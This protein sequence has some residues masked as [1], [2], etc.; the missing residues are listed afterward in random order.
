MKNLI[1]SMKIKSLL[2][3]FFLLFGFFLQAE[4]VIPAR[5]SWSV[6]PSSL[7]VGEVAEVI[8]KVK[9]DKGWYLYSS[10]FDPE[11][12]PVVTTVNFIPNSSFETIG[13]LKPINPHSK[14]DKEIWGGTYTYFTDLGEFRQKIKIK[15]ANWKIEGNYDSQACSNESGLCVPIKGGFKLSGQLSKSEQSEPVSN[16]S[17]PVSKV[18]G[19]SEL[20]SKVSE[21]PRVSTLGSTRS[22]VGN[23]KQEAKDESLFSFFFIALGAGF[24]ALLTP[25]V[26][27]LIPMTVS[28]FTKQ[29]GGKGLA[30]LYGAFIVL[31]YVF[32]GTVLAFFA[33]ASFANFLSTH[34][35]PNILFFVIFMLFGISF[36]GAFE[37]VLPS[38]FVNNVDAKSDKGGL[39]GVF[40]MAFT[41][42]LVSFS[43]TGPLAGSILIAA[44][45]GVFL[46]PIIGMLGFSL[47]FAIPFTL[48]AIFP[49]VLNKMPK[50]GGWMNEVK[51]VLGFLEVALAFKFLSVADQVYHWHLL[52]REVFLAIWIAVFTAIT[53]YLFG[54]ISMPHDS[55]NKK[56]SVTRS[57]L[58]TGSLA[59]VLYLM[60]GMW[61]APLKGLSG[62]LPPMNSQD[63]K[64]SSGGTTIEPVKINSKYSDFLKLPLGLQGYFDFKEA[65]EAAIK[66]GKPLFI[67][68]TGH[69]C[70][71][72]R[73]MEEYVWSD[74]KV[75]KTL[76]ED[77]VVVALYCDDKTELPESMWYASK[78]DGQIK[79][80]L[81]DQNLDFQITRFD[82][83]AQ[84]H[85]VLLD[86]RTDGAPMVNPVAFDPD[87]N[88]FVKFLN[89]GLRIYRSS[90]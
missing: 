1:E 74:P 3:G 39:I 30:F 63:F 55:G 27:P 53:L 26:Y 42:V 4:K 14:F 22:N 85:Y 61:G 72:C 57:L 58:A 20:V 77:Y 23:E 90:N 24:L 59:F 9:I 28:F 33:G 29:R 52:D 32:F 10:D 41:L 17:E 73:K 36:L 16:V 38:N 83:N 47:A 50:S 64:M 65:K 37:I 75:L 56:L 70:V 76:Q 31:I 11:L 80:T 86:P 87:V 46:K 79:K 48:F 81:G 35:I 40:F 7:K 44:S 25:C 60:P 8:F 54:L 82:S 15:S 69:G 78:E 71:N 49:G 88:H 12:G 2:T 68:F 62:W 84:P 6:K 67:D 18:S 21:Q 66:A 45:Q 89:E 13:K 5:W 34:W 19:S 51:V 43:C